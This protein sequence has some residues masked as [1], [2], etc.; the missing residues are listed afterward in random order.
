L[1]G[2]AC[3][4]LVVN[5][6]PLSVAAGAAGLSAASFAGVVEPKSKTAPG[7]FLVCVAAIVAALV[8]DQVLV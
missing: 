8:V 2:I 3:V 7:A 1:L 5:G 4:V 6:W